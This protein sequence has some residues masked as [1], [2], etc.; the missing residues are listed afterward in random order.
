MHDGV[1]RNLQFLLIEVEK[2]LRRTGEYLVAPNQAARAE[3]IHGDDYIDNL[4]ASIQKTSFGAAAT[5]REPGALAL[6]RSFDVVADNLERVADLCEKVILQVAY[7][8][9]SEVY[10]E[11]DFAAFLREV[12]AGVGHIGKALFERDIELALKICRVEHTLNEMYAQAFQ[13]IFGELQTLARDATQTLVTLLL[14][15]HYLERMGDALLNIGEAILSLHLGERVKISQLRALESSLD[16]S[17][18]GA[19]LRHLSFE[20]MTATKS[21]TMVKCLSR[22]GPPAGEPLPRPLILKQ[23]KLQKLLEEKDSVAR[24][25]RL[26]PGLAP[27]IYSFHAEGADAAILFEYLPGATFEAILLRRPWPEVEHALESILG[28]LR[29]VWRRTQSVE[30]VAPRFLRQLSARLD[31]VRA[32][33]PEFLRG[34]ASLG[35]KHIPSFVRLVDRLLAYDESLEAPFS[36]F[37]H[38]DFNLDNVIYDAE[39]GAVRFID[40]HRST[41]MDY[42][43]DIS[44]FLVSLFRLKVMPVPVRAHIERTL[45]RFFDFARE[46]A[47]DFG[48]GSFNQRLALGVARSLATSTRFVLDARL[49]QGMFMRSRYILERLGEAQRSGHVTTFELPREVLVG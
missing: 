22:R 49:A 21:G 42:V 20:A 37:I 33:H 6:Y 14:I 1:A 47:A 16:P 7:I 46:Q 30:R 13:R 3:I 32:V 38:G 34:D 35:S 25:Q 45:L 10:A 39:R 11:H 31:D 8:D 28:K 40:L 15:A 43:Q 41:Q 9:R 12:V 23:G 4:E 5:A 29:E 48:D 2:Q 19:Q 18:L 27:R 26:M 17:A 36:V 44:V 24:W